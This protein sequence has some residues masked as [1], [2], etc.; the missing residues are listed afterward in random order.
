M[1]AGSQ[2]L[3]RRHGESAVSKAERGRRI[4]RQKGVDGTQWRRRNTAVGG[5]ES[6]R[7]RGSELLYEL[8]SMTGAH[9]IPVH[10]QRN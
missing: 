10:H 8:I 2:L 9:F 7:V 5:V 3:I 1:Y 4:L 6:A